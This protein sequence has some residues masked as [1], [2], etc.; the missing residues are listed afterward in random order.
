MK[1]LTTTMVL[2]VA[3]AMASTASAQWGGEAQ[4]QGGASA[5]APARSGGMRLGIQGRIDAFNMF[6]IADALVLAPADAISTPFAPTATVGLRM[7][8]LWIG[9]GL[10]FV[11][12]AVSECEEDGCGRESTVSNSGFSLSPMVFFDILS[13]TGGALAVGGWFNLGSIGGGTFE[14]PDGTEVSQDGY[15]LWGA[16]LAL[17]ARGILTPGLALGSELG[18]GFLTYSEGDRNNDNSVFVHGLFGTI[19]VEGSVGI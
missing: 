14:D 19:F 6:G 11:G 10:G 13:D 15:F 8:R 12:G 2:G 17:Q 4:A 9:L 1:R 7:D 3:L 16:N 5:P 18:W